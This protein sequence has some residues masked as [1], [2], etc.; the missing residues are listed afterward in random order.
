MGSLIDRTNQFKMATKPLHDI[1]S[2]RAWSFDFCEIQVSGFQ[3]PILAHYLDSLCTG[4]RVPGRF[5]FFRSARAKENGLLISDLTSTRFD[6]SHNALSLVSHLTG[7]QYVTTN[8]WVDYSQTHKN[9]LDCQPM[10][11]N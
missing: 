2:L 6:Q 3:T 4:T 8:V 10:L 1:G 7:T 11:N 5:F 9:T